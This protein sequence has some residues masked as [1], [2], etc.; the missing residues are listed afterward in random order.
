MQFCMINDGF[1]NI[2]ILLTKTLII[3]LLKNDRYS[4]VLNGFFYVFLGLDVCFTKLL[5]VKLPS[6]TSCTKA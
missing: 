4:A 3:V 6:V 5:K 2:N 1:S